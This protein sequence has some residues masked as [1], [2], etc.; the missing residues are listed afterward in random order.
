MSYN[1][2]SSKWFVPIEA[3]LVN[4]PSKKFAYGFGGAYALAQGD[5]SYRWLLQTR[6]TFYF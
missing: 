1:Y 3:M 4:R 6:L 5:G 2:R